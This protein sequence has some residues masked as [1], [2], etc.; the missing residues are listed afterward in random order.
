VSPPREVLASL[1][2]STGAVRWTAAIPAMGTLQA[3]IQGGNVIWIQ[4]GST[5]DAFPVSC[6]KVCGST[7]TI[8]NPNIESDTAVS[9]GDGSLF[10]QTWPKELDV[11]RN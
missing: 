5:L 11:Y 6:A 3:P 7:A 8:S 9:V 1:N 4:V 10:I 2:A